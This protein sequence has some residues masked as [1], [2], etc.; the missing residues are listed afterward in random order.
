MKAALALVLC[1]VYA[2]QCF[3]QSCPDQLDDQKRKTLTLAL[4]IDKLA[5]NEGLYEKQHKLDLDVEK[6]TLKKVEIADQI[7]LKWRV[8]YDDA[9]ARSQR[10]WY[11]HP[12]LFVSIGFVL[13]AGLVAGSVAVYS[14][15]ERAK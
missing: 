5:E 7:S 3:A 6:L 2:F 4:K 12:A 14:A 9:Q 13:A 10:Q 8:M 1:S 11:E 15:I